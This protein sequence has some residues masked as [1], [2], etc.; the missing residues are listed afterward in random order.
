[1]NSKQ[2]CRHITYEGLQMADYLK[3]E[4]ELNV[5]E[6][7]EIFAL[8]TEINFNPHNFGNKICCGMGCQEEQ[9]NNHI[10]DCLKENNEETELKFENVLNGILKQKTLT[11]RKFQENNTNRTQLGF[12]LITVN[13]LYIAV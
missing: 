3:P 13:P 1:M 5:I 4:A 9:T 11:F 10:F 12:S 6:K 7:L 2:K 8:R